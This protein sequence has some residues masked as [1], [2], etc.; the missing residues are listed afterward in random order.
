[1]PYISTFV[2]PKKFMSFKGVKVYHTYKDDEMENGPKTYSFTFNADA[3]GEVFDVRELSTWVEPPHPPY[4]S[5][6]DNTP[7]NQATWDK[8]FEDEVEEK[9]IQK[10]IKKAILKGEIG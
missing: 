7:E 5:G 10:A 8:Y 3:D 4:L 9:A 1:M 2:S 6:D